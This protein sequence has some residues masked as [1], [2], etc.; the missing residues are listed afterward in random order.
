ML[1]RHADIHLQGN[2][3]LTWN[4]ENTTRSK[5]KLRRPTYATALPSSKSKLQK[6][7][8]I[9]RLS[10]Q[11]LQ[12]SRRPEPQGLTV[13]WFLTVANRATRASSPNARQKGRYS[14]S[15]HRMKWYCVS[16]I[17]DHGIS[18]DNLCRNKVDVEAR[19]GEFIFYERPRT[20]LEWWRL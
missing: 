15:E 1:G 9:P 5:P 10:R 7:L 11:P 8:P 13:G 6:S 18:D 14:S 20:L 19:A 3:G 12:K 2:S 16:E 17:L 4:S